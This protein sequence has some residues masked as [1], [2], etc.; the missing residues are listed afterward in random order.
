MFYKDIRSLYKDVF[1]W[2]VL[3]ATPVHRLISSITKSLFLTCLEL[4]QLLH[5]ISIFL[6]LIDNT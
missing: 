3:L 1:F 5:N 6:P 4:D 2:V